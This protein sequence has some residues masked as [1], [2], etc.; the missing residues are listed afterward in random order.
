LFKLWGIRLAMGGH[1]HTV[2]L[3]GPVYDAPP[4]YNPITKQIVGNGVS[5]HTTDD[6][7]NDAFDS[8]HTTGMFDPVSSVRP[9]L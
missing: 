5:H 8:E 7:L 2:A 6:I 3:T 9:F 1:K 4:G